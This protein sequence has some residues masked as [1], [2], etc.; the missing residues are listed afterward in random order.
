M[1]GMRQEDWPREL[2]ATGT[3]RGPRATTRSVQ[4]SRG[5]LWLKA[6]YSRAAS[7]SSTLR[8]LTP[9]RSKTERDIASPT[10]P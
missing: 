2:D 7:G 4:G 1:A 5:S 3:A 8:Y 9:Q 10:V 6:R